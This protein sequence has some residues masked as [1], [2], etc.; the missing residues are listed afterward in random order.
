M[1]ENDLRI[2]KLFNAF[3]NKNEDSI[4]V[5]PLGRRLIFNVICLA[6]VFGMGTGVSRLLWPS[7]EIHKIGHIKT[8]WFRF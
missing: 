7:S 8:F 4:E 1:K 2:I 3:K 6:S 5:S